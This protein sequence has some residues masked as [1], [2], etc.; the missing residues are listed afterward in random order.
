MKLKNIAA[1]GL[2]FILFACSHNKVQKKT[3]NSGFGYLSHKDKVFFSEQPNPNHLID[4]K[5]EENI[6]VVI[7]LRNFKE[8]K[9]LDY[10][11]KKE[12][13]KLKLTYYQIPFFNE[14]EGPH[15][16][17]IE[18]VEKTFMKHHKPGDKILV[19]CSSGNRAAAWFGTHFKVTHK[20]SDKK[21]LK[22]S[23]DYG[24]DSELEEKMR[25]YYKMTK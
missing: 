12:A 9:E 22:I 17:N 23:R 5:R 15:K 13:Q 2:I 1:I 24:M 25:K 8:N 21:A 7:N 11:P 20:S 6:D 18:K 4:L 14:L 19:H 10:N 16:K 3:T